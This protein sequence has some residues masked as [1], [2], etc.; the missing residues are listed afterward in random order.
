MD[1]EEHKVRAERAVQMEVEQVYNFKEEL[2]EE[3]QTMR[4]EVAEGDT[5][6]AEEPAEIMET[7]EVEEEEVPDMYRAEPPRQVLAQH[8]GTMETRIIQEVRSELVVAAL[9]MAETAS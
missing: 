2:V 9:Q 5:M 7:A 6:V 1:L 3:I 8:P 4:V